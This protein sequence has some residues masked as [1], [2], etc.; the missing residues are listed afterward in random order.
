[1]AK[2]GFG[3]SVYFLL[4]ALLERRAARFAEQFTSFVQLFR[5]SFDESQI[6]GSA[7]SKIRNLQSIVLTFVD[8]FW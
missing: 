1:L 8:L 6:P 2:R 5:R 4:T 3:F 7:A